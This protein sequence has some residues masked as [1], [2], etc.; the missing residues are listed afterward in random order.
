MFLASAC[1]KG[2]LGAMELRHLRYF[3]AAAEEENVTRAA[4]KLHVSQPALS[5]Q[6]RDLEDELGVQLLQRSAKSVR[7]TE[8]GRVFLQEARAVLERADE[9]MKAARAAGDG[10]RGEIHVGYAP[11]LTIEILPRALR[12]F[13]GEFPAVRVVLHD[14]STE[15]MLENLRNGKLHAALGVRPPKGAGLEFEE[16]ARYWIEAAIAPGHRWARKRAVSRTEMAREPLIAYC[17]E[18]Y[19]EYHEEL[20]RI[21]AELKERPKIA[22]EHESV[23]GL[24]A[25]VE[26]GRGF[27]LAPGCLRCMA[28]GRVKMIALE[29]PEV[30][31]VVGGIWRKETVGKAGRAFLE[32]AR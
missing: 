28:G 22:E 11:S 7:L 10:A 1:L 8:A 6:I 24:I 4:A 12:R 25:A 20:D 18:G 21:F 5:R 3:T 23:T 17:R 15:E 14:F 27:A 2:M 30:A 19:P 32:A 9:A 26:A 16:I 31:V 29:P 13:Q